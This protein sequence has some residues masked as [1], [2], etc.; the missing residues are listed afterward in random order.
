MHKYGIRLTLLVSLVLIPLHAQPQ[1]RLAPKPAL[2]IDCASYGQ[3]CTGTTCVNQ[4]A[5]YYCAS[6]GEAF[7]C[8]NDTQNY[9][10]GDTICCTGKN[11]CYGCP[12]N[13]RTM[14]Y[15]G[16]WGVIQTG[17]VPNH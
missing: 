4:Q 2:P 17:C 6:T 15:Y 16:Y 14:T 8:Q 12:Y 11:F 13:G 5:E 9:V 3:P 10:G 1:K 7:T